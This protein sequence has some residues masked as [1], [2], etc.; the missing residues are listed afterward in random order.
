VSVGEEVGKGVRGSEGREGRRV[1]PPWIY[2]PRC[3][4]RIELREVTE[5]DSLEA[6]REQGYTAMARGA[7]ECGAVVVLCYQPL[8]ASPTFSLFMDIYQPEAV[9]QILIASRPR[10]A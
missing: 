7:C 6:M 8:P 1:L 2:C 5:P 9:R 10:N 4:S 3:G